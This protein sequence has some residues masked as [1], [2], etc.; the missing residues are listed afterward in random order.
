MALRLSHLAFQRPPPPRWTRPSAGRLCPHLAICRITSPLG[1]RAPRS[2]RP[3]ATRLFSAPGESRS[4]DDEAARSSR[5]IARRSIA[6]AG[7]FFS[8]C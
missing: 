2:S 8:P 4:D 7:S 6:N 3:L 5:S 1:S